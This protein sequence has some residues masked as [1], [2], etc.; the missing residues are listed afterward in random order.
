MNKAIRSLILLIP[1]IFFQQSCGIY[2]LNGASIPEGMNTFN[3]E[4]FENS[5]P[6]VVPYLSQEL[7]ESLKERIRSQSRLNQVSNGEADAAFEGRITGYSIAPAAVGGQ[8][9]MAQA[10]RLTISVNVKYVDNINPDN[11]FE[12]TFTRFK[13][14]RD[15]IQSQ[16]QQLI[17]DINLML[18]EDIFNR[19]FA[20]W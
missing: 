16:E 5:A 14:F 7:T 6:I 20:N 9:D 18:T 15:A 17:R 11:S 2:K 10:N 8:N 19:A 13:D 1:L 12:Q 3:V 4:I